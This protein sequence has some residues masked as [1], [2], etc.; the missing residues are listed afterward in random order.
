MDLSYLQLEIRDAWYFDVN[1]SI[2]Q[3]QSFFF[4]IL[5]SVQ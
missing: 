4:S 1:I 2:G 5:V 3:Y